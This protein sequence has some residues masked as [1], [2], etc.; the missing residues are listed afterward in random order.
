MSVF[1]GYAYWVSPSSVQPGPVP[2]FELR[3]NATSAPRILSLSLK[4]TTFISGGDQ[5]HTIGIARDAQTGI[6]INAGVF[7]LANEDA[8]LV[9]NAIVGLS[10]ITQWS[11]PPSTPASYLRRKT[12]SYIIVNIT[13]TPFRFQRGL[14]IAP[15]NSIVIWGISFNSSFVTPS[16]E[17]SEI[18]VDG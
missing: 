5:Q 7:P 17:L 12:G 3:A 2:M 1:S 8:N 9:N 11:K 10:V 18:E 6:P 15:G 4:G 14:S 13:R 16:Y